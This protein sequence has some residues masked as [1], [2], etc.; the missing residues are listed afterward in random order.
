MPPFVP[1]GPQSYPSEFAPVLDQRFLDSLYGQINQEQEQN[2]GA[3][4]GQAISRGITGSPFE[5][6]GIGAA[7]QQADVARN[8]ALS[9]F[10]YNLAGMK[11]KENIGL[12]EQGFQT[13]EREAT[14]SFQG[15]QNAADRALGYSRLQNLKDIQNMKDVY[16]LYTSI[17]G[18]LGQGIGSYIGAGLPGLSGLFGGGGGAGLDAAATDLSEYDLAFL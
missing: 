16:G 12:E 9:G 15:Q 11:E 8:S 18:G 5:A 7:N 6:A 17:A 14:Q 3:A 1:P 2:V 4:E 13:S 10:L